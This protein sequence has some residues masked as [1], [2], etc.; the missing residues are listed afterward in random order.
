MFKLK[1]TVP[2]WMD[3]IQARR[4]NTGVLPVRIYSS[5][6]SKN[7]ALSQKYVIEKT[8]DILKRSDFS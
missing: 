2:G 5:N 1:I 8:L 3:E 7:S 4:R 6:P